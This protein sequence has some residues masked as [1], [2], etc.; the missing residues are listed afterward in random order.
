MSDPVFDET[1]IPTIGQKGILGAL[2]SMFA[3]FGQWMSENVI[4]G[5]LNL[6]STFVNFLDTISGMFGYPTFFSDLF[7]WI[8]ELFGYLG[9]SAGYIGTIATAL[10]SLFGSLLAAFLTTVA[11]LITNLVATVTMF[12]DMMGGAYGV[13]VN[14]WETFNIAQWLQLVMIL[15]PLYLVILWDEKG[16]DAVIQQLT[17]I[18]GLL[19]WLFGFFVSLIQFTIGLIT[20]VIESIPVAE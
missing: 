16:M 12:S 2:W 18:F 14:L 20:T 11:D 8:A 9:D 6:W 13:G 4:F 17:W 19:S 5:G 3:G 1:L 7:S 15:Y 10:F